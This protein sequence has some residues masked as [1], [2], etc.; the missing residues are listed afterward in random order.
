M[1]RN[2]AP[3]LSS[4]L[5]DRVAHGLVAVVVQRTGVWSWRGVAEQSPPGGEHQNLFPPGRCTSPQLALALVCLR[6]SS[7]VNRPFS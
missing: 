4:L 6:T 7:S 5:A 2:T 1:K 3:V